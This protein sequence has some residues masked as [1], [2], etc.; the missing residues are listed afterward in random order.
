MAFADGR[1][2]TRAA[3]M[4][5]HLS[6]PLEPHALCAAPVA[7]RRCIGCAPVAADAAESTAPPAAAVLTPQV[8]R[9]RSLLAAADGD[10]LEAAEALIAELGAWRQDTEAVTLKR[11]AEA[12]DFDRALAALAALETRLAALPG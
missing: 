1:Q 2:R 4:D 3:G 9:L 12:Y 6:K 8:A 11:A 7:R 10:A 5:Q